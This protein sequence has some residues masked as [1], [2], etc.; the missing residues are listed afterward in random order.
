MELIGVP[1][2]ASLFIS[3]CNC[4]KRERDHLFGFNISD[5]IRF[6]ARSREVH[7]YM[8]KRTKLK[9]SQNQ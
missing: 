9:Q 5:I 8:G 4:V 2:A 1:T 3:C 6:N 7:R